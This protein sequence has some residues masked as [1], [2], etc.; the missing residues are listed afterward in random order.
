MLIRN[1]QTIDNFIVSHVD[2]TQIHIKYGDKYG[3]FELTLSDYESVIVANNRLKLG[4]CKQEIINRMI[5]GQQD[6][7]SDIVTYLMF[8]FEDLIQLKESK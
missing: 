7:C 5:D 3:A 6:L 8:F 2:N 1:Q 4:L